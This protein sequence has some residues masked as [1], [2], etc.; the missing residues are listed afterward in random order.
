M[1]FMAETVGKRLQRAMAAR[2]LSQREL[3]KVTKLEASTISRFASDARGDQPRKETREKLATA[4]DVSVGWLWAGEQ[5][6]PFGLPAEAT[7]STARYPSK[8]AAAQAMRGLLDPEAI[9]AMITEE[10]GGVGS[11]GVDPGPEYWTERAQWWHEKRRQ[12]RAAVDPKL[13]A[14]APMVPRPKRRK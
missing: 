8:V 7:A 10:A 12:T 14:A 2:G 11:E 9:A 3:A 5:P 6:D 13:D 1:L 4:L